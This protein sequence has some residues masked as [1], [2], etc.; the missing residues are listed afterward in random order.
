MRSEVN[1]HQI[2]PIFVIDSYCT[3]RLGDQSGIC[4]DYPPQPG[5]LVNVQI[6]SRESIEGYSIQ[7]TDPS[8]WYDPELSSS[9]WRNPARPAIVIDTESDRQSSYSKILV[10]S[11]SRGSP[12]GATPVIPFCASS[13][14]DAPG[15]EI[16]PEP[17]W[18]MSHTYC[19]AFPRAQWF[20]CLPGQV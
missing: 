1:L 7:A 4:P 19:Y 11:L 2:L 12:T 17:I 16:V 20:Y 15:E 5:Q 8:Y 9:K 3:D 14:R 18:P 6:A 10:V 13:P